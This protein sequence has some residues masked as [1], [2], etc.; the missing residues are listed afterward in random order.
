MPTFES[1]GSSS[2]SESDDDSDSNRSGSSRFGFSACGAEDF[3]DNLHHIRSTISLHVHYAN[4][5]TH[6]FFT[7][8]RQLNRRRPTCTL[9][10]TAYLNF[11]LLHY[12]LGI[13]P[14]MPIQFE[15]KTAQ[16]GTEAGSASS[17]PHLP[18][19]ISA[20]PS[21]ESIISHVL[22]QSVSSVLPYGDAIN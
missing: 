6:W 10:L 7:V 11:L 15:W 8:T 2:E 3:F 12:S 16:D 22:L 14:L 20:Y 17:L 9:V 21:I 18:C 5:K 19:K 1:C 4:N 13:Y